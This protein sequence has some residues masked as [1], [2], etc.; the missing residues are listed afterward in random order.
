MRVTVIF[1]Y[2]SGDKQVNSECVTKGSKIWKTLF[3]KCI[4]HLQS[5]QEILETEKIAAEI[6][7]AVKADTIFE[8]IRFCKYIIA[9]KYISKI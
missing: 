9:R 5:L 7:K 2:N 3:A 1:H 6:V 8:S 4:F